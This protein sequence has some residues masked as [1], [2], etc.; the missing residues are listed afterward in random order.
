ML[1]WQGE[2]TSRLESVRLLFG[3]AL[4]LRASGRLV[5]APNA[6]RPT[7][8]AEYELTVDESGVVRRMLVRSTTLGYERQVS[9][10]RSG[11]GNWLVDDGSGVRRGT[12]EGAV[13][14]NIEDVLFTNALPI[15][16]LGL[17]HPDSGQPDSGQA[18]SGQV[19]SGRAGSGQVGSGQ[20]DPGH[21]DSGQVDSDGLDTDRLD[22]DDADRD[23]LDQAGEADGQTMP[24]IF[25]SLPDLTVTVRQETYR[26]TSPA[27][28]DSRAVI[29]YET[30]TSGVD[31]TVT[32]NG[33]VADFPGLAHLV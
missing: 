10:S 19:D 33:L 4:R 15:R 23:D 6:E 18:G 26:T 3:P 31:L 20:V 28:A 1:T 9:M 16:R 5:V 8:S 22:S 24:V 14:V 27:T 25:V 21:V 2:S 30:D 32:D 12:F 13:T 29:R 11:E 7:Y 17:H